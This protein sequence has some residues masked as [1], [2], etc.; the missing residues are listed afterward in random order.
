MHAISPNWKVDKASL[1]IPDITPTEHIQS[2]R[3]F[4]L[5]LRDSASSFHWLSSSIF[6]CCSSV[7][8]HRW[9]LLSSPL[10]DV[11][12][13]TNHIFSVRIWSW[14]HVSVNIS[15]V[16]EL[17]PV[18]YC[19]VFD[20]FLSVKHICRCLSARY[21]PTQ[22]RSGRRAPTTQRSPLLN[23]QGVTEAE[24]NRHEGW[25]QGDERGHQGE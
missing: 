8:P 21:Q 6:S 23:C 10:Y 7:V 4:V 15:S 14:Q 3:L 19:L 25:R 20:R 12:E 18:Y 9:H 24:E 5:I 17:S 1:S 13:H 2:S 22:L 11:S 16:A